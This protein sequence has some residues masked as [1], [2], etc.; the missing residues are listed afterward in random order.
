MSQNLGARQF[1]RVNQA[2]WDSL[3]FTFF[4]SVVMWGLLALLWQ[5]IAVMFSAENDSL[6]LIRFFCLFVA[7]SFIFN[8]ALFVA[9][10]AFNNLGFPIY[11]TFFNW[12]RATLGVIP[13]VWV[14]KS[15]GPEGVLAG[16]G[17]GG[18]VFGIVSVLVCFREIKKLPAKVSAETDTMPTVPTSNSPF[19]SGRGASAWK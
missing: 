19:T 16:W 10:A 17:L 13:F 6:A 18:I 9:N 8:G 3:I 1:A 14:G 12:G 11:S 7:G 4:Y 2:M 15:W 5:P